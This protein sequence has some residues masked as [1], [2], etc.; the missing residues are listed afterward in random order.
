[1]KDCITQTK[2]TLSTMGWGIERGERERKEYKRGYHFSIDLFTVP[3]IIF[4]F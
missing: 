1:M 3:T 4:R 2:V